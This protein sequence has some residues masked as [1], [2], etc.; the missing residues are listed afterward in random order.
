MELNTKFDQASQDGLNAGNGK[1]ETPFTELK[2]KK[3]K[4]TSNG[5]ANI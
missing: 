3:R 5:L 2:K 1:Q 4:T